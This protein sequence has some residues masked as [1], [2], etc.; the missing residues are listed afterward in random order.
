M[1]TKLVIQ[2]RIYSR[3]FAKAQKV[4]EEYGC[5]ACQTIEE[6]VKDADVITTVTTSKTPVI[7][8]E[9]VKDG[10]HVNCKD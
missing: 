4:A 8:V 9:W 7:K 1:C 6:A 2:V 3:T 10:A 5:V